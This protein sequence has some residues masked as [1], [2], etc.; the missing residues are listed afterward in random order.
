ME[1]REV[2][3]D[4]IGLELGPK[5]RVDVG[6]ENEAAEF[7]VGLGG[8]CKGRKRWVTH[9]LELGRWAS[10]GNRSNKGFSK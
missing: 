7:I 2:V 6:L 8:G 5:E 1:I 9:L 10:R 4:D 3:E